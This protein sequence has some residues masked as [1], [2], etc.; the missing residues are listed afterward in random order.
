MVLINKNKIYL[1]NTLSNKKEVFK[2][3]KRKKVGMYHC[4]PTVYNKAHIGNLVTYIFADVLRRFFEQSGY[5]VNQVINVTDVGHLTDDSDN[6]EDKMENSA[7]KQ[8][9]KIQSIA[10]KYFNEYVEDLKKL[11]VDVDKIVFPKATN[12]IEEQIEMIRSIEK[13]GYTYKITDGI[14]FDTE[15]LSDYGVLG[16]IKVENLKAG[17]RVEI[18]D[19]KKNQTDFA[20]WKFSKP[21]DKRQQEWQSP[22]GIGFPGWHIECSAMARKYLG[23][24]F[25]IHTGGVDHINIHH[26]NEIAQSKVA[27]KKLLANY[28]LHTNHILLNDSKISKSIGNVVY[29]SDLESK[30]INPA[31]FRYW[32]LTSHYSTPVNFTWSS[33]VTLQKPFQK[34]SNLLKKEEVNANNIKNIKFN[35]KYYDKAMFALSDNLNTAAAISVISEILNDKNLIDAEKASTIYRINLVLGID[36]SQKATLETVGTPEDIKTDAGIPTEIMA[37]ANERQ[38]ARDIK[39]FAKSDEI[40]GKISELGYKIIDKGD[41]FSIEK[42]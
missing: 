42:Q 35:K 19:E 38:L 27:D 14:Y 33:L 26:N 2:S 20:L 36:F 24:N 41:E 22:W 5:K 12:H 6:G 34:I 7:K 23:P 1:K 16:N 30:K 9:V 18:N 11:N 32:Y 13:A 3:N 31:L 8:G 21:E 39:D 15:K 17:A 40:R 37:L 29:I 25:D 28:W 10:E 4:G